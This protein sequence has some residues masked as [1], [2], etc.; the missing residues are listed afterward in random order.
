ML[1]SIPKLIRK[2][3]NPSNDRTWFGLRRTAIVEI[4][5]LLGA[6]LAIDGFFLDGS[7]F[8]S[9]SPHPFAWIVLL[10]SIQYGT[11]EGLLAAAAATVALLAGHLPGR[12]VTQDYF[13]WI[14][15]VSAAPILWTVIALCVGELRVRQLRRMCVLQQELDKMRT[16]ENTLIGEREKLVAARD[17]LESQAASQ[18]QTVTAICMTARLLER[19]DPEQVL[20]GAG[21]LMAAVLNPRKFSIFLVTEDGLT[22]S[23]Q[24]GWSHGDSY[25]HSYDWNSPL[26]QEVFRHRSFCCP[27][28]VGAWAIQGEGVLAGPLIDETT[29]AVVGMFK[30]EEIAFSDL[31]IGTIQKFRALLEWIGTAYAGAVR[32]YEPSREGQHV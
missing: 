14:Y 19:Q 7:R 13:A 30:I 3:F 24:Q 8:S 25:A 26:F 21:A 18:S 11:Y 31:T 4:F 17:R 6:A 9:W 1:T 20:T 5:L 2:L 32:N 29:N 28:E 22:L 27:G 16:R 10:L 12:E 15:Q 23:Y